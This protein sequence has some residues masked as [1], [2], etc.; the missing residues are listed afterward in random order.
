[1]AETVKKT[2]TKPAYDPW[3]DMVEVFI[4]MK[5][6][7]EQPTALIRINRKMYFVPKGKRTM[8]PKPVAKV[9]MRSMEMQQ[10]LE[11]EARE[12]FGGG[13]TVAQNGMLDEGKLFR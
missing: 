1:M 8:V 4:P 9:I 7:N 3:K 10:E 5:N 13:I 11:E 6:R 12:D 2:E